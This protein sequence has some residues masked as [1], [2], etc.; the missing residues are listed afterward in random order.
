V[1][2]RVSDGFLRDA[3]EAKR[4]VLRQPAVQAI[5]NKPDFHRIPCG[6]MLAEIVQRLRQP[7]EFHLR[8]MQAPRRVVN[9]AG[10]FA[11]CLCEGLQFL[12][13]R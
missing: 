12:R 6:E 13:Q 5:I 4:G 10:N 8:G 7:Q 3:E 9:I 11:R 2:V 1:F